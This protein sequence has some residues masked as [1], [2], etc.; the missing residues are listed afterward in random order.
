MRI[1]TSYFA[2]IKNLESAG[3]LPVAICYKVPSFFKG[4]NIAYVAPTESILFEYKREPDEERYR[5]RYVDEVLSVFKFHPEYLI[6]RLE[7]F[8]DGGDVAL[9]CYEKPDDFCHRHILAE[10]FN[11]KIPGLGIVEYPIYPNNFKK[12]DKE[13]PKSEPLF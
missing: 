2:N 8:N 12:I 1:Y 3:I 13:L 11:E 9:V 7:F 4:I 6:E 5:I 10:W